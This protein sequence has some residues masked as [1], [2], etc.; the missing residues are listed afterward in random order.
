MT[1]A[2]F[3]RADAQPHIAQEAEAGT[4]PVPDR[5]NAPDLPSLHSVLGTIDAMLIG[6]SAGG[7]EALGRILPALPADF[8]PV[9]LVVLHLPADASSELAA[10]FA[11]RCK[12]PV[13]EL[14]DREPLLGGTV[15]F[16]PAGYHSLVNADRRCALSID[17]AVHFSRPSIDVLFESAAWT[18]G[19]RLLAVLL[20]GASADGANGMSV[21]RAEGGHTWAQDP[22]EARASTMPLAAIARGAVEHVLRIDDI[23]G[24]LSLRP[25]SAHTASNTSSGSTPLSEASS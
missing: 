7:V 17:E 19:P 22:T 8:A 25:V 5:L 16:A 11:P 20:T 6:A 21:V 13:H 23:V 2:P 10:L 18:Y 9:V 3:P 4:R 24:V 15:Y 14:S 1:H 12:L